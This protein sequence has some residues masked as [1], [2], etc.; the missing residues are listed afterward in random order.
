[1]MMTTSGTGSLPDEDLI[2]FEI[3]DGVHRISCAISDEA[4]ESVSGLISPFTAILRR[5]SFDRFRVLINAAAKLKLTSRPIRPIILTSEDLR[6]APPES[7]GPL[8]G[9]PVRNSTR[10]FR[11]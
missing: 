6:R 4:L 3:R 1:M 9:S 5:R 10:Q 2:R 7:G 8:F 11:R